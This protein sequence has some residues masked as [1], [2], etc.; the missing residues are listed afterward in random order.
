MKNLK[1][2]IIPILLIILFNNSCE[3]EDL[4]NYQ[5]IDG[6]WRVD[7]TSEIYKSTQSIYYVEIIQHPTDSTMYFIDNFYGLGPG[8]S[9]NIIV[10]NQ[11]II[12]GSQNLDGHQIIGSG[13]ITS[14]FKNIYLAY[15]VDDSGGLIDHV[16]ANYTRL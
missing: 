13:T 12:I 6:E 14:D 15:N 11:N 2:K 10:N 1:I 3:L 16:T 7:E 9:L 5:S 4:N 8:K